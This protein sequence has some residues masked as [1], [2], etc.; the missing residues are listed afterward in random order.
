MEKLCRYRGFKPCFGEKCAQFV[1]LRGENPNTG[2]E[3]DEGGC[4][5]AW[6]PVLLTEISRVGRGIAKDIESFR[7]ET[8]KPVNKFMNMLGMRVRKALPAKEEEEE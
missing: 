8:L 5:E 7:N 2:Q 4:A 1:K 3:I 6:T